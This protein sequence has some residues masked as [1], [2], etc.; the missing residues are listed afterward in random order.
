L[1]PLEQISARHNK[2]SNQKPKKNGEK[3]RKSLLWNHIHKLPERTFVGGREKCITL[4]DGLPDVLYEHWDELFIVFHAKTGNNMPAFAKES[5]KA[6]APNHM[7]YF[8][9]F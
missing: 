3:W 1:K 2:L 4:C 8:V 9:Y 5:R 6:P 7:F